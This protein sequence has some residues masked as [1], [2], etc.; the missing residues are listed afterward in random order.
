MPRQ[1]YLRQGRRRCIAAI[2]EGFSSYHPQTSG[3]GC[4]TAWCD[5]LCSCRVLQADLQC[6]GVLK[7][8]PSCSPGTQISQNSISR[9]RYK[10]ERFFFG[11]RMQKTLVSNSFN[12]IKNIDELNDTLVS[13]H[14]PLVVNAFAKRLTRHNFVYTRYS[15]ER[16][17]SYSPEVDSSDKKVLHPQAKRRESELGDQSQ[18]ESANVGGSSGAEPKPK[19]MRLQRSGLGFFA[20]FDNAILF[21]STAASSRIV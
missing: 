15:V 16:R 8:A 20:H 1:L 11:E 12:G 17:R 13:C 19:R 14:N 21:A 2:V 9:R 3:S 18:D 4:Y 6:P 10:P 5:R 7:H